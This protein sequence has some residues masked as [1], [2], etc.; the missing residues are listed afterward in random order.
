ME[1]TKLYNIMIT[2]VTNLK[3]ISIQCIEFLKDT[4]HKVSSYTSTAKRYS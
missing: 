2:K 4:R 1:K 3:D